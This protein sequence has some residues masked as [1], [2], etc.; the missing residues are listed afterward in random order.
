MST[1]L[2]SVHIIYVND[3]NTSG[4]WDGSIEHPYETI[5]DGI[6]QAV[7]GD[8]VFVHTGIYKENI[9]ID[10]SIR[11]LGEEKTT[12][13]IDGGKLDDVV[14]IRCDDVVLSGFTVCNSS[15]DLEQG[16]WWKAGIRIIGSDVKII[17]TIIRDNLQGIFLKQAENLTFLNN[18]FINDGLTIYPY[19]TGYTIRPTVNRSYYLHQIDNNT[20]NGKPLLYNIDEEN[21][22]VS[23]PLGQLIL[24]NCTSGK[25]YNITIENTDFPIIF[26]NCHNCIIEHVNCSQNEGIC[27]FLYSNDNFIKH[28]QFNQ[29]MHGFLLD[30]YSSE[31]RFYQNTFSNNLFC[32]LICEYGSND[33]VIF[34]NNFIDNQGFD[35]FVIKS[36]SNTWNENY[37]SDW[38]GMEHQFLQWFP[39]LIFGTHFESHQRIKTY[40]NLDVSPSLEQYDIV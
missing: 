36:F 4:P 30:Y 40:I 34:E 7:A 17:D 22:E 25:I 35:A 9:I 31:N 29:N 6:D 28:S 16:L 26:F 21:I 32:G 37:W 12:T 23:S 1:S 2:D 8:W 38:I 39:K 18:Q 10:T 3:D 14:S 33:N 19:D 27:S 13:I 5:Q 15:H 11:L 20:V 24:V